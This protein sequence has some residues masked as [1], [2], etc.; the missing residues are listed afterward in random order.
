M[1]DDD[2]RGDGRGWS[3]GGRESGGSDSIGVGIID[4]ITD[5]RALVGGKLMC[6]WF[7]AP[8]FL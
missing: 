4:S 3:G 6:Q 8:P 1:Q 5:F 7:G 2:V